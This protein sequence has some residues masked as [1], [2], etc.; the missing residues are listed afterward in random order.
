MVSVLVIVALASLGLRA[1]VFGEGGTGAVV[2]SFVFWFSLAFLVTAVVGLLAR[3]NTTTSLPGLLVLGA[4]AGF[5]LRA[6]ASDPWGTVGFALLAVCLCA[7]AYVGGARL[8]RRRGGHRPT[9][10]P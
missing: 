4:V 8:I 5:V 10:T 6:A 3:G 9:M 2:C 1:L 7:L